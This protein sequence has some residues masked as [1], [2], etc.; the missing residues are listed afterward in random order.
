MKKYYLL[1]I[2]LVMVSA[3]W[4]QTERNDLPNYFK[5]G[6]PNR[7]ERAEQLTPFFTALLEKTRPVRVLHLGDSHVRGHVFTVTTRREL[8]TAWGSEAVTEAPI[9]YRTTAL[10]T[11]TGKPGLVY[12]AYGINGATTSHFLSPELLAMADTLQPDLLILSFGTNESHAKGYNE[13]AHRAAMEQLIDSLSS[14]CT[15]ATI[16]LTTP[17]G[18]YLRRYVRRNGK[19]R[20]I[21]T[22]NPRTARAAAEIARLAADR[23]LPLW[24]LYHIAG[25]EYACRNWSTGRYFRPDGVHFTHE[26]Y[27]LQGRLLARA[28]LEATNESEH[29]AET[30]ASSE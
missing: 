7:I 9:T 6:M 21:R 13:E 5:P 2:L 1:L 16:M 30:P 22:S 17:P 15:Q 26:G 23:Q 20:T 11:E 29:Y 3:L 10:A 25:G 24:D 27:A 4:A 14:R 8:E 18:E 12:N 28:L 19:R